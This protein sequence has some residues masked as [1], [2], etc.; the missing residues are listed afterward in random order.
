MVGQRQSGR[1]SVSLL[2][3]SLAAAVCF[4]VAVAVADDPDP[5]TITVFRTL[6]A[7]GIERASGEQEKK[8]DGKAKKAKK[9]KKKEVKGADGY[10]D[11]LEA[12]DPPEPRAVV[13]AAEVMKQV[14]VDLEDVL[15]QK[16]DANVINLEKQFLPQFTALMTAELSFINRTCELSLPQRKKIKA[17]SDKCLKAAV[18]KYAMT[19]NGMMRGGWGGRQQPTMP[20][21]TNLL[22][23]SLG[24]V[25]SNTL[26]G[27][28]TKRYDEEMAQR[29]AVRKRVAVQNV[30]VIIDDHLVLTLD[31]RKELTA[32]LDKNWQASWVQSIE[33]LLNNNQY[34]PS[35]PD[36][37]VTP[38]LK[39]TQKKVWRAAQKQNYMV[40]GGFAW[41]QQVA[42]VDDFLLED[43]AAAVEAK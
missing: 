3:L 31:Q 23:K 32:L 13:V 20:D 16:V 21:P 12:G 29:N 17:A 42:V 18:R 8:Q 25:L 43:V 24:N 40:W 35:I 41:G 4:C 1:R 15:G 7:E 37:F 22:H 10:D 27:A 34:L 9:K 11:A 26:D 14:E 30:V 39:E 33:M 28:Q 38:V 6:Q 36:R 19:Q 2:R 5:I